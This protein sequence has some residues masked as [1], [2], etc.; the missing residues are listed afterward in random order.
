MLRTRSQAAAAC[1]VVVLIVDLLNALPY[2][3]KR[4]GIEIFAITEQST[5]PSV[6]AET[7]A[8][9]LEPTQG[10]AL[11]IGGTQLDEVLPATFARAWRI[12]IAGGYGAMLLDR[13]SRLASMGANGEVRPDLLADADATLDALAVKYVIVNADQLEQP[14]RAKWLRGSERWREAM[15]VRTTRE[16]WFRVTV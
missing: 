14:T 1:L 2:D 3:V 8:R 10:R 16:T 15:H 12:P 11:A 5:H 9:W 6:H 4:D 7:I 13:L